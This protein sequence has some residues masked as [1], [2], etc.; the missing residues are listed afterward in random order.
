MRAHGIPEARGSSRGGGV[1]ARTRDASRTHAAGSAGP[2]MERSGAAPAGQP[3][4]STTIVTSG[5]MP[6]Y[7]LIATL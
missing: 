4:G 5:V 2:A 3:L 7:T 1:A 6:A